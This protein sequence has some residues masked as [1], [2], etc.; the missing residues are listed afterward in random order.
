[1][2]PKPSAGGVRALR[3]TERGRAQEAR[4]VLAF[5]HAVFEPDRFARRRVAL[6]RGLH[7]RAAFWG[8]LFSGSSD[9]GRPVLERLPGYVQLQSVDALSGRTPYSAGSF[10]ARARS[11]RTHTAA[12]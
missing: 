10:P 9:A 6:S 4:V 7:R 5:R 8:R 2:G 3:R 11:G 1:M 12:V